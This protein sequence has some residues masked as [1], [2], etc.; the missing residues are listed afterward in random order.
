MSTS[1]S[2]PST[3]KPGWQSSEL[4][5]AIATILPIAVGFVP[6]QYAPWVAVGGAV[7]VAARTVLKALHTAGVL[8]SVPDLPPLP[9][10]AISTTT[11]T[12]SVPKQ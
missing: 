12:T 6:A 4:Y 5:V 7:Y 8:G 11:T 9:A 10:G 2:V 1:N 3:P